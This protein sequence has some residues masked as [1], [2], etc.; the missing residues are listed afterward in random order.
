[1]I[2]IALCTHPLEALALCCGLVRMPTHN[3]RQLARYN[4]LQKALALGLYPE[5]FGVFS[6]FGLTYFV[7][8]LLGVC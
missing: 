5:L 7:S 1:M 3:R 6:F 2:S 4:G 8:I